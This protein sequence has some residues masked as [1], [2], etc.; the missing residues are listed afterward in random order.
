MDYPTNEEIDKIKTVVFRRGSMDYPTN[1]EIDKIKTWDKFTIVDFHDFMAFIEPLWTF[2]CW[3]RFGDIYVI[4]TAGWSGNEEIIEAM[5]DNQIFWAL[6]WA[7]STR[8]G[9]YI[10]APCTFK[11]IDKLARIHPI[12]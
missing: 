1:E 4:A 8:G 10:F 3:R 5:R 7:E 12:I 6:Y 11:N 9:R 2:H